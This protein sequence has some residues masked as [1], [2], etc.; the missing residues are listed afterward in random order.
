LELRIGGSS[1]LLVFA[2]TLAWLSLSYL[3]ALLG[4]ALLLVVDSLPWLFSYL[5]YFC[6]ILILKYL[7]LLFLL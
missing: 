7:F 3:K 2:C 1:Y 4:W 5:L 6:F